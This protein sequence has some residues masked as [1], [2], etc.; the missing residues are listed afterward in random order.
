MNFLRRR[1][2]QNQWEEN[3]NEELRFH[4]E[5]QIALNLAAGMVSG[6]STPTSCIAIRSARSSQRG[7]P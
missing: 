6:R 2:P 3:L 5:Q 4:L 1:S 7:L